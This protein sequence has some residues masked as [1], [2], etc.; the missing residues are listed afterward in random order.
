MVCQLF[1]IEPFQQM[2]EYRPIAGMTGFSMKQWIEKVHVFRLMSFWENIQAR[3][4]T[5]FHYHGLFCYFLY[6]L[7][8]LR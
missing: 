2:V 4:L 3:E 5:V 1:E 7:K 8:Q 6:F